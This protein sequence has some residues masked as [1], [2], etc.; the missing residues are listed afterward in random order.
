LGVLP[1][2][3]Q[4]LR[5]LGITRNVLIADEVHAYDEYTTH[6][7]KTLLTFHARLGGSAILL[8]ATLPLEVKQQLAE[9]F[10]TGAD[11]EPPRLSNA[12]LPLVTRIDCA[13]KQEI[14]LP[15]TRA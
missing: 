14:K 3:H 6:L 2:T 8:S 1:S 5:L 7:L 9:A 4:C 15:A 12:P 10:C 11:W 13:G